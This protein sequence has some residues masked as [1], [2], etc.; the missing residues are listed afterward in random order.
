MLVAKEETFGPLAPVFKFRD[1]DD[2]IAQANA[3]PFGLA[4]Y[5]YAR[6]IGRVW[7]I[8]ERIEAGIVGA[9]TG[10]IS[11]EVAPFGGVKQSGLGR[12]GSKYGIED[13]LEI[14][15]LCIGL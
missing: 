7:R 5:F 11:T 10:L 13:Y 2:A 9:N 8:A 14:K 12:E 4:A 6:D 15:Y 1:E 3:T